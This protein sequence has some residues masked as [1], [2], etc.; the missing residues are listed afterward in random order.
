MTISFYDLSE[1]YPTLPKSDLFSALGG[2]W[3][4]LKNNPNYNNTCAIRLSV[5]LKMAGLPVPNQFKEAI[6][7][8]GNPLILKVVTMSK[9]LESSLGPQY[10]GMSKEPS[11]PLKM[12][13]IPKISGIIVYHASW[14][15]A[16][17]HFDLWDGYNFVGNG[18]LDGVRDGFDI[19]LWRID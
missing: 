15:D 9:F 4:Q 12:S 13:H 5:A 14:S 10:W 17:G 18:N 19:A 6:D 1:Y 3:P 7:G 16:T 2:Q 11:V 8:K